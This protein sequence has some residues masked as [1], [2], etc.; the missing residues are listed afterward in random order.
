MRYLDR[1]RSSTAPPPPPPPSPLVVPSACLLLVGP[2]HR[3]G[4]G[5]RVDGGGYGGDRGR[6]RSRDQSLR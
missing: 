2:V 4:H 6:F 1:Y 3:R 5:G